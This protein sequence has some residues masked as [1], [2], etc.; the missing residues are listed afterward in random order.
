M[1]DSAATMTSRNLCASAGAELT[2][3]LKHCV[4]QSHGELFAAMFAKLDRDIANSRDAMMTHDPA[5]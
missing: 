1:R 2:R 4:T 5:C 3:I